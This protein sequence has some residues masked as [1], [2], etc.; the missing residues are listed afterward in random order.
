MKNVV[1]K[2]GDIMK[3]L[4]AN[5]HTHN[6]L[7][8]HAVGDCEAYVL[9]AIN[10]GMEEIGITDHNPIP[11]EYLTPY[12]YKRNWCFRNMSYDAFE[13]VYLQELD[14]VIEKYG[15]KI[16]ILKGVEAEYIPHHHDYYVEMSKKLDYMLLGLH[17]F[18]DNEKCLNSYGDVNYETIKFYVDNAIKAM[19]TGLF[20]VFVHPDLFMFN[21]KNINGER[22]FDEAAVSA[23]RQIIEAAIKYDVYLE[24]NCNGLQNTYKRSSSEWLYPYIEFWQIAKEYKDLKIIIGADAHNPKQLASKEVE[25]VIDFANRL[26]LKV[27]DKIKF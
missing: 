6:Q 2:M 16:R 3:K 15:D 24:L 25:D 23:T 14:E 9:E 10:L 17:F 21:Y 5:Y 22:K 1:L 13:N 12:Y 27:E 7:C 18:Y 8:N 19:S 11:V 20:K 26:G 4:I